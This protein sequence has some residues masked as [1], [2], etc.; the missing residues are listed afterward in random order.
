[1]H[2]YGSQDCVY[3]G[4]QDWLPLGYKLAVNVAITGVL[5]AG[6]Y[7]HQV[8]QC[9]FFYFVPASFLCPSK[10]QTHKHK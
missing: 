5:Y 2:T 7:W 9:K 10:T 6:S 4:S 8:F 1:M 3:I